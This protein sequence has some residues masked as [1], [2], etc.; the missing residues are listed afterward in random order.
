MGKMDIINSLFE[1]CGGFFIIPSILN[2]LK[3]KKVSGVNWL[4]VIFFTSWGIWNL[5]F[6]HWNFKIA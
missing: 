5:F 1:I 4:T 6:C 3:E 2:L